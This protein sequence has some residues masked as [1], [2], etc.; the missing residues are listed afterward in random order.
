M[1]SRMKAL[2]NLLQAVHVLDGR[3][4]IH[5]ADFNPS[6]QRGPQGSVVEGIK[7]LEEGLQHVVVFDS[8]EHTN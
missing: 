5:D 3:Q 6:L 8:K 7:V 1:P 2:D 4:Q